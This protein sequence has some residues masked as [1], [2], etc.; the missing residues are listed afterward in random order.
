MNAWITLMNS[1]QFHT[2][3]MNCQTTNFKEFG[4]QCLTWLWFH[5]AEET[6]PLPEQVSEECKD[7]LM[8]LVSYRVPLCNISFCSRA[9]LRTSWI[10][11][12]GEIQPNVSVLLTLGSSGI[13]NVFLWRE[14]LQW[15]FWARSWNSWNS[16]DR[17]LLGNG[18]RIRFGIESCTSLRR[19]YSMSGSTPS[20]MTGMTHDV[21]C[22]FV[23]LTSHAENGKRWWKTTYQDILRFYL[24]ERKREK[25]VVTC[26]MPS[27]YA[28]PPGS[29]H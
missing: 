3:C 7:S 9:Q 22:G 19:C 17:I 26:E 29:H 5:S 21:S 4:L 6:P 14:L 12:F 20:S 27:D 11:A 10:T 1:G 18:G 2:I 8:Q 24:M 23:V 25:I 16:W 13:P 28:L 15:T